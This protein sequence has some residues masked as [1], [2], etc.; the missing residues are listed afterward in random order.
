MLLRKSGFSFKRLLTGT[1][2]AVVRQK[3]IRKPVVVNVIY[4][5]MSGRSV[6]SQFV[7]IAAKF[8]AEVARV[9][10]QQSGISCAD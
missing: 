10:I 5:G 2:A 3:N 8:K 9:L 6:S 4:C 1:V 7:Q